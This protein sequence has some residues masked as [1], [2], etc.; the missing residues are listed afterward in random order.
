MA[1]DAGMDLVQV[2]Y[3]PKEQIATAKIVDYGKYMYDK[4]KEESEKKK[5][6]GN[7]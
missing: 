1:E 3:D 4:Q 6:Q 5:S 2:A 7:K